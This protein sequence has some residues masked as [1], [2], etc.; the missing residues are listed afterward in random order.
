M[1]KKTYPFRKGLHVAP[2]GLTLPNSAKR[3]SSLPKKMCKKDP[4]HIMM[5]LWD[6]VNV[7]DLSL[8]FGKVPIDSILHI[9]NDQCGKGVSTAGPPSHHYLPPTEE[10]VK[11]ISATV[12]WLATNMGRNFLSEFSHE[13]NRLNEQ[14]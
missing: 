1:S 13:V 5:R 11:I 8:N 7:R 9:C 6:K 3:L 2:V 4:E 14:H 12:Q 10:Q